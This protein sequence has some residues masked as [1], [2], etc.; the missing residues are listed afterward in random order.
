LG[1]GVWGRT[2][3]EQK[4]DTAIPGVL[5]TVGSMFLGWLLL[6]AIAKTGRLDGCSL[7]A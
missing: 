5:A 6:R 3:E 1:F 4:N 2:A 7:P